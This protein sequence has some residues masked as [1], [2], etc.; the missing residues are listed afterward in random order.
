MCTY[1]QYVSDWKLALVVL[2][3]VMVDL[4]ILVVYTAV[5]GARGNLEA[6][7]VENKENSQDVQ[8]VSSIS[9]LHIACID[10]CFLLSIYFYFC[11]MLRINHPWAIFHIVCSII[12][13][14]IV[15][16]P[17]NRSFRPKTVRVC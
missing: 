12:S 2:V 13:F 1:I 4:V 9:I 5:E 16:I 8:G 3:L 11:S 17:S 15:W 7:R 6:E 10:Y 14:M